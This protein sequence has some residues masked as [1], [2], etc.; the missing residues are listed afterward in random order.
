MHHFANVRDLDFSFEKKYSP[1]IAYNNS[2]LYTIWL[3]KILAQKFQL[4]K[5]NVSINSYHPG[6]I[7]T[8]LG[9]DTSDEKVKNSLYGRFM[10]SMSKD[11]DEGI[12]TVYYLALSDEI[13]GVTGSY[14]DDKQLKRVSEKNYTEEK[15]KK[16]L[17]YCDSIIKIVKTK[18]ETGKLFE[19]LNL[20]NGVELPNRFFKSAMSETLGDKNN[21][22][23]EE[24][25][26]LYGNWATK[27]IGLVV[28]GNVMVDRRY[29]GESGNV[30]LDEKSDLEKFKSWA[31]ESTKD[32]TKILV[33]LNHPGKQM[34]RSINEEPIAPSAIPL[35]GNSSSAFRKPREMTNSEIK[36]AVEKFV[37]A[38]KL[39]KNAG[40]S[41][42]QLHAAHGYLINQFLSPEDNRRDDEYG[43]TLKNRLRFLV[44]IYTRLREEVG[45]EFIIALKLNAS[46]FKEDGFDFEDCKLVAQKMAD[47]GVDLIGISGGN[48]ESPVFG[49]EHT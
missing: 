14:F 48:Y 37:I 45:E 9:N 34:Y 12:E 11:L 35:G 3:T 6:L 19:R 27:N 21:N 40:F 10:K 39:V 8:N 7:S 38:G 41:G 29:L 1:A 36:E 30:V 31:K 22:P 23:S 16:L 20:A 46:D 5:N 17:E 2:K 18:Q 13:K 49:G 33:Q 43:G 15:G 47:L 4:N 44:E 42:V 28:T 26:S 24:L 25:I 32:N